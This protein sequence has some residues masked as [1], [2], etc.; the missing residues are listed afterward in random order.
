[1]SVILSHCSLAELNNF[2]TPL[3]LNRLELDCFFTKFL[4]DNENA[5][6]K[7]SC[8]KTIWD[9]YKKNG[10]EYTKIK[11][12]IDVLDYYIKRKDV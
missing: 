8:N 3:I 6:S 2:K 5:M 7:E 9:T 4:T 10:K 12:S 11:H 1:M